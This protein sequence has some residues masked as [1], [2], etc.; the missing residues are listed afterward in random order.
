M[1]Q[2]QYHWKLSPQ[3]PFAFALQIFPRSA[4]YPRMDFH[5]SIHL[6]LVLQGGMTGRIGSGQFR[7][8]KN[9]LQLTAPWELHGEN[10]IEKSLRL[11]SITVD[12]EILLNSLIEYRETALALFLLPPEERHGFLAA[13]TVRQLVH[14][15]GP[16]LLEVDGDGPLLKMRR[17][18]A[19]QGFFV[20]L[21]ERLREA[22]FPEAP[23]HLHRKLSAA[24][25]LLKQNR[26][27]TL[28]EAAAACSLSPGRFAHLFRE[29][30]RVPFS[31]YELRSRLNRAAVRLRQGASVKDAAAEECFYDASHFARH[32]RKQFGVTPGKFR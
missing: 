1:K 2:P 10:H 20:E 26:P 8:R 24:F 14:D 12:P 15:K 3:E 5:R 17:W 16:A 19:I 27:V 23:L 11:L 22:D 29:L 9:D 6:N 7:L 18:L 21:L 13:P 32:F 4:D 25:E 30:C 31:V 28:Q